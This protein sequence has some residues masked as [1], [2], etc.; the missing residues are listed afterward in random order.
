MYSKRIPPVGEAEAKTFYNIL[1][2]IM[3]AAIL[4]RYY[5]YIGALIINVTF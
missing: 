1:L 4:T 2:T 3:Q 5:S